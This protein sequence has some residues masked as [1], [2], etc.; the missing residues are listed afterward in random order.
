MEL[1]LRTS[2]ASTSLRR[3]P[4]VQVRADP[5]GLLGLAPFQNSRRKRLLSAYRGWAA[6]AAKPTDATPNRITF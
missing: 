3:R 6:I 1:L 5:G 2:I 4:L